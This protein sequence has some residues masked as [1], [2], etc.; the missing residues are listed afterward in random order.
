MLFA[1]KIIRYGAVNNAEKRVFQQN[2]SGVMRKTQQKK[3]ND[4]TGNMQALEK[5]E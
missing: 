1:E 3:W 5:M 2:T 4:K